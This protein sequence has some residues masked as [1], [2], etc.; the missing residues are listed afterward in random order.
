MERVWQVVCE[1]YDGAE[2]R[3]TVTVMLYLERAAE[4][5]NVHVDG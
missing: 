1:L 3:C 5:P 2:E 4:F